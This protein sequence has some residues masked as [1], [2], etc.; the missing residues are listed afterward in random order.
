MRLSYT[1]ETPVAMHNR[2]F[3]RDMMMA[4]QLKITLH[5]DTDD[6]Q[7]SLHLSESGKQIRDLLKNI[8]ICHVNDPIMVDLL[9]PK[10]GNTVHNRLNELKVTVTTDP[11]ILG[12][13]VPPET[14]NGYRL[15]VCPK[16]E[17][18]TLEGLAKYL[19]QAYQLSTI[20]ISDGSLSVEL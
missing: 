13:T 9:E 20:A 5:L 8:T 3:A 16:P 2:V 10:S 1:V 17:D 19:K 12:D 6:S 7:G 18:V 11:V 4:K 15:L 14:K